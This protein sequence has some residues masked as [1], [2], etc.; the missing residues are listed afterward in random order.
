MSLLLQNEKGKID[1]IMIPNTM[2]LDKN[3]FEDLKFV[4][5]TSDY[6]YYLFINKEIVIPKNKMGVMLI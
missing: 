3:D 5:T 1:T 2:G 4:P 6:N